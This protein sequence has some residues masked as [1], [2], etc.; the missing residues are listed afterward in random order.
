MTNTEVKLYPHDHLFKNTLVLLTPRWIKPNHITILRFILTPFVVWLMFMERYQ[1]GT[2]LFLLAAFT[3]AWDG[4]LARIRNQVT[5]WGQTYDPLADKLLIGS[6]FLT[7]A[8]RYLPFLTL[9]IVGIEFSFVF[10]GWYWK[11]KGF[12][13]KANWWGKIKMLLQVVGLVVLLIAIQCNL[14]ILFLVASIIFCLTIF[15]ALAS[16]I[17]HG[18]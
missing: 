11:H 3:D 16:L 8:L 15:F 5:V 1:A 6:V 13:I 12:E 9:L 10:A 14:A 2:L 17:T 4:S 7:V 18:I